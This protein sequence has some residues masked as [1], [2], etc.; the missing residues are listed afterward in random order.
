[1]GWLWPSALDEE[2]AQVCSST[3]VVTSEN[4][5]LSALVQLF[6]P[7]SPSQIC[8]S[9]NKIQVRVALS[10]RA[11]LS[12]LLSELPFLLLPGW[13]ECAGTEYPLPW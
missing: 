5:K 11:V 13:S 4:P 1:M 9:P 3:T 2:T 10:L 8:D 12:S 7:G 6:K